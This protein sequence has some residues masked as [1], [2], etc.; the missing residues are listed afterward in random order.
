[1]SSTNTFFAIYTGVFFTLYTY[2]LSHEFKTI[3]NNLN[4]LNNQNV[5]INNELIE[6]RR[7]FNNLKDS[8]KFKM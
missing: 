1:M 4:I 2:S 8:K 7:D 3:K 6:L 5:N